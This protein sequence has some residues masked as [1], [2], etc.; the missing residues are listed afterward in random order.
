MR[1]G[2]LIMPDLYVSTSCLGHKLNLN[3]ILEVYSQNG[4]HDVEL[5]FIQGRVKDMDILKAYDFNYL[6]HNYFPPQD[7]PFLLNIASSSFH[8][9]KRSLSF[10]KKCLIMC[11][12]YEIP[13]YSLHAGFRSTGVA[14]ESGIIFDDMIASYD[15]AF[16]IMVE[17]LTK[18]REWVDEYG[19]IVLIENNVSSSEASG[20]VGERVLLQTPEEFHKLF[21]IIDLNKVGMLLD[22]GHFKV[23]SRWLEFDMDKSMSGLLDYVRGL[24][25]HDNDGRYDKHLGISADS[26]IV[27]LVRKY[28]RDRSIPVVL[29]S[30]CPSISEVVLNFKILEESLHNDGGHTAP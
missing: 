3:D 28:F 5:G 22:L 13:M 14:T 24:H 23:A 26:E 2:L 16:N 9:L 27:Y 11:S 7:P 30:R 15:K 19:V 17:S 10:V 18:I 29:E 1:E 12:K 25:V 21:A 20:F 4:F 8:E 6:V